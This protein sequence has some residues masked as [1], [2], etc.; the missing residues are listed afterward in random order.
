[1]RLLLFFLLVRDFKG[2]RGRLHDDDATWVF[3]QVKC[4]VAAGR[5]RQ[6]V[7]QLPAFVEQLYLAACGK[8]RHVCL[9]V[10]DGRAQGLR[11]MDA[12]GR[13]EAIQV[14]AYHLIGRH[15]D[16]LFSA[17]HYQVVAFVG[18]DG[19]FREE[20]RRI[21]AAGSRHG[22]EHSPVGPQRGGQQK[23]QQKKCFLE[24]VHLLS[25]L[26]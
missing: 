4:H 1:M 8:A 17:R 11:L 25:V 7:E 10:R 9:S 6:R 20:E 18:D 13:A 16:G 12:G 19:V 23:H 5:C 24:F 26:V 15:G 3:V 21:D 14:D 2:L 22:K